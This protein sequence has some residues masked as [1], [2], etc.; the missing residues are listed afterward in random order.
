MI[1]QDCGGHGYKF[2]LPR[3]VNAFLLRMEQLERQMRKVP[4]W[5]CGGTGITS[6][7]EGAVGCADDVTN[8]GQKPDRS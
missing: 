5:S 6:C 1:C 3:G 7:C 2:Q 8:V 4:C